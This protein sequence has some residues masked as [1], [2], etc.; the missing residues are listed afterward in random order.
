MIRKNPF[1]FHFFH[2]SR[3]SGT[4]CSTRSGRW[5]LDLFFSWRFHK[6]H[7][8]RGCDDVVISS[9]VLKVKKEIKS[10]KKE[11]EKRVQSE[12]IWSRFAYSGLKYSATR[13][14]LDSG[15]LTVGDNWRF[16]SNRLKYFLISHRLF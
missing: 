2:P 12:K 1:A 13:N 14:D 3:D 11:R 6:M 4:V 16:T 10:P 8:H 7:Q 15:F 5:C 9:R